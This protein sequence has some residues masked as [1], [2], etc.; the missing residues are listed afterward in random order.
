MKSVKFRKNSV[1][2][3]D[4]LPLVENSSKVDDLKVSSAIKKHVL[5]WYFQNWI[6]QS[7]N[8][9]YTSLPSCLHSLINFFST[10]FQASTVSE[11]SATHR[12]YSFDRKPLYKYYFWTFLA[13]T[14]SCASKR[15]LI[16]HQTFFAHGDWRN[17]PKTK[18]FYFIL[19][20]RFASDYCCKITNISFV[21]ISSFTYFTE[22]TIIPSV[23]R[24]QNLKKKKQKSAGN[25]LL[26]YL[27]SKLPYVT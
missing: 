11:F 27:I 8:V 18:T 24:Y 3:I 13:N 17:E 4:F 14:T 15:T 25:K 10:T 7:Y 9:S 23:A 6:I 5:L 2:N 21:F 26:R 19:Y 16:T 20:I 22:C 1:L 12:V